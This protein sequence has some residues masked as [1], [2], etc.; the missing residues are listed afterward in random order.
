MQD[1]TRPIRAVLI[2]GPTASGKS[3]L[4]LALAREFGG[5][6]VNADASQVYADL[7][8]LTARPSEDEERAAPHLLY[9]HVDAAEPYAV[10]RWLADVHMVINSLGIGAE[11]A[12]QQDGASPPALTKLSKTPIFVGGTGLY[13]DAMT[14]GLASVPDIPD[15]IRMKWRGAGP[16]VDLHAE[17]RRRD[18]EMAARLRPSDPQ[19][20][21]RALEVI[22]ATGR[23]LADWQRATGA[24][25]IDPAETLRVVLAPERAALRERIARRLDAM[26]E[27]GA[28]AEAARFAARGLGPDLPASKALGVAQFA[29]VARGEASLDEALERTR[30]DTGRYA[31]RQSTWFRN[32]MADWL[33]VAPEAALDLALREIAR[34]RLA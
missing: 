29:A 11:P 10:G 24:G 28:V 17:L 21:M 27:A 14:Q 9:G 25:L 33:H 32:R 5:V 8:I 30:L 20:L 15:A 31:K 1:E 19:R 34:R 6:V 23:S 7:R 13:L 26:V 18:P 16:E 3:A 22:D 12:S 2:A 4:A